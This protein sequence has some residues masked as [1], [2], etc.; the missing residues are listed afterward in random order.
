MLSVDAG[1]RTGLAL[2]ND[3]AM[4]LWYRSHNYGNKQRLRQDVNNILDELKDLEYIIIE[5]GGEIA[6]VWKKESA[7]KNIQVIQIYA[8]DWRKELFT[9]KK[10]RNGPQAKYN[11]I[12]LA[13]SV[14]KRSG[15]KKP[16]SLTHDVAEAVLIGVWGMYHIGW[17]SGQPDTF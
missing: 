7:R 16:T 9:S 10:M 6:S 12:E 11:A 15:A 14:I 3:G 8:E 2:F 17:I 13:Q 1:V 4:L 5:G